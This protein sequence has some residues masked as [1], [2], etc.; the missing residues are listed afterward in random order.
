MISCPITSWQIEGEKVETVKDFIFL[1]SKITED[2]DCSHEIKRHSLL[3]RKVMAN[4]DS[5]LKSRDII[6]PT[7][8]HVVKV[9]VF[10]V[11]MYRCE[12]WTV[13]KA[14]C[15]IIDAFELW[16]WRRLLRV[17]WRAGRSNQSILK[18]INPD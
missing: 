5:A 12:S 10:P 1:G 16:C 4:L 7:K 3:G 14:E 15:Q 9:T 18:D 2:G 8:A 13:K 6:L 17:P 11:V